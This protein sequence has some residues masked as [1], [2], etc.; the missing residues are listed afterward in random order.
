[1]CKGDLNRKWHFA[2]QLHVLINADALMKFLD[3]FN[4]T[5]TL[6]CYQLIVV[7]LGEG[8]ERI[9]LDTNSDSKFSFKESKIL[10]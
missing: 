1:M 8:Q 9:C 7:G 10:M 4:P 2:I 3:H 6:T 5:F